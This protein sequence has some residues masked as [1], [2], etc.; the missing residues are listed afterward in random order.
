MKDKKLPN[1]ACTD[2]VGSQELE[3]GEKQKDE[4]NGKPFGPS[5]VGVF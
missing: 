3:G 4:P 2:E 5:L 1:T